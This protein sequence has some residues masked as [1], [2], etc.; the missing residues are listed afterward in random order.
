MKSHF[1]KQTALMLS[2]RLTGLVSFASKWAGSGQ[3]EARKA[4]DRAG[5]R[6]A[7]RKEFLNAR[8]RINLCDKGSPFNTSS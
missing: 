2:L 4:R 1:R 3:T 5:F 6:L 8:N 7:H